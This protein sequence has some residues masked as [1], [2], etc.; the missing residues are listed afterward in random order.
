[1]SRSKAK[2][3]IKSIPQVHMST[4]QANMDSR[5]RSIYRGFASTPLAH[6]CHI[7]K[8]HDLACN[9]ARHPFLAITPPEEVGNA[10]P[11]CGVAAPAGGARLLSEHKAEAPALRWVVFLRIQLGS[12]I[13]LLW[14]GRR[15][16]LACT[17]GCF[18]LQTPMVR[19]S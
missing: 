11:P 3:K 13:G 17:M 18:S 6:H 10:S 15:N 16:A 5:Q 7:P 8:R 19:I 2:I 9:H 1:L 4:R 12:R 14:F